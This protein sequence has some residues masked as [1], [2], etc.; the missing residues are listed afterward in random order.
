MRKIVSIIKVEISIPEAVN[1]LK[2]IK[3]NRI[4]AFDDLSHEIKSAVSTYINEL[5]QTEMALFL[6]QPDQTDNKRNGYKER[7]Y[8]FKGIGTVRIRMPQA[9]KKGFESA[10]VPKCERVDPR[11]KEDIAILSLAGLSTR[12]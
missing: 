7:N 9:R 6:G 3:E 5:L 11:L 2:R 8:T 10:L 4:K 12:T 1:A